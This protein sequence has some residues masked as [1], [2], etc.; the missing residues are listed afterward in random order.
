[1]DVVLGGLH[2]LA[3]LPLALL[4]L[5]VLHRAVAAGLL[6]LGL[7]RGRHLLLG[8]ARL[9]PLGIRFTLLP[10]LKVRI[11]VA[12]SVPITRSRTER[13]SERAQF[14]KE[15]KLTWPEVLTEG[16]LALPLAAGAFLF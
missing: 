11:E 13:L 4:L 14:M 7:H 3:I 15:T 9:A 1:M 8:V 2:R 6:C 16:S 10:C 12:R 5:A